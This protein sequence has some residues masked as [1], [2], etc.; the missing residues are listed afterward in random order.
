MSVV[1]HV[2]ACMDVGQ[3]LCP[4]ATA[5]ALSTCDVVLAFFLPQPVAVISPLV[6]VCL[7]ADQ[8]LVDQCIAFVAVQRWEQHNSEQQDQQQRHNTP[9]GPLTQHQ[10]QAAAA[11][12]AL[13]KW[14]AVG[15]SARAALRKANVHSVLELEMQVIEVME[16]VN[17][18]C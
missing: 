3:V 6:C 5:T 7:P 8:Q 17:H 18:Y 11:A 2:A 12:D 15:R 10:Q 13:D 9:A 4:G 16:Q 14:R 1:Q